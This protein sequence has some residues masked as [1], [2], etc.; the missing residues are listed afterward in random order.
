MN[1]LYSTTNHQ[2]ALLMK[3]WSSNQRISATTSR[4]TVMSRWSG[5]SCLPM[6]MTSATTQKTQFTSMSLSARGGIPRK[7]SVSGS[8]E[9]LRAG[10][11]VAGRRFRRAT[12][13]AGAT[14]A[15]F[16]IL[17]SLGRKRLCIVLH[18]FGVLIERAAKNT[19]CI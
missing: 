14:A 10:S 15:V 1:E 17:S 2:N 9:S 5:E 4:N 8:V 19:G 12:G 6:T 13:I 7:S 3:Y 18:Y 16:L 11:G